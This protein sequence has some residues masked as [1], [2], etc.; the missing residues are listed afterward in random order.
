MCKDLV[1]KRKM[2]K[3]NTLDANLPEFCPNFLKRPV[4]P[5]LLQK[6]WDFFVMMIDVD[7][8][9]RKKKT[10]KI[11]IHKNAHRLGYDV[12][13]KWGFVKACGGGARTPAVC[14][15]ASRRFVLQSFFLG[16]PT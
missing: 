9:E 7:D 16:I 15:C 10:R 6:V 8:N 4:P 13:H 3:L 5:R 14:G 1:Q 11:K 2:K 12:S